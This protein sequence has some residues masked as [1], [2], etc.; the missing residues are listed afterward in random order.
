MTIHDQNSFNKNNVAGECTHGDI[1]LVGGSNH[2]EGRVE[3][4][5]DGFWGT[6][7]DDSWGQT[8]AEV[9][10]RQLGYPSSGLSIIIN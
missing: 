5:I 6:V 10:C 3:V 1:K 4:C 9:V 2:T 8:D 7:C